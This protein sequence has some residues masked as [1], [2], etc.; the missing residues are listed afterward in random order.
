MQQQQSNLNLPSGSGMG[1]NSLLRVPM[2]GAA[3]TS[4]LVNCNN[5]VLQLNRQ[6]LEFLTQIKQTFAMLE[7]KIRGRQHQVDSD[8]KEA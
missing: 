6:L 4:Q 3:S 1:G 2:F 7:K 5:E 8:L